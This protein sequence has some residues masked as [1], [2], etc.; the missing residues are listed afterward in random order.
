MGGQKI[1]LGGICPLL[2]PLGAA[3]GADQILRAYFF[4]NLH[5]R[6]EEQKI[7]IFAEYFC[8]FLSSMFMNNQ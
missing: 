3:T 2:P 7:Q 5:F 8:Y 6:V 1:I 4:F